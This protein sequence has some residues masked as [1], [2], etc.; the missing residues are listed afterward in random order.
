[1]DSFVMRQVIFNL[2]FIQLGERAVRTIPGMHFF[3]IGV[4]A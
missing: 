1:M 3:L 2:A 4:D